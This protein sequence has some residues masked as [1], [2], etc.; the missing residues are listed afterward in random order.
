MAA[1]PDARSAR[2]DQ[3][4]DPRQR[5]GL[6]LAHGLALVDLGRLQEAAQVF[7]SAAQLVEQRKVVG[8]TR[9]DLLLARARLALLRGEH[10]AAQALWR[11]LQ[12]QGEAQAPMALALSAELEWAVQGPAAALVLAQR[13]LAAFDTGPAAL[14]Q[15]YAQARLLALSAQAQ[16]ALMLGQDG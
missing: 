5:V 6:Q 1:L 3:L 12:N 9:R 8:T 14:E 2:L 10:D 11:Q 4:D 13:H 16:L 7:D 15:P